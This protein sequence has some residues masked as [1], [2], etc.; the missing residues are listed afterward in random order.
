MKHKLICEGAHPAGLGGTRAVYKCTNGYG[1]SVIR[2]PFSY[3]NENGL[4]EVGVLKF[5]DEDDT[6]G[7]LVYTEL[8]GDT[9]VG[10]LNW[11]E[12][13][14]LLDA[15]SDIKAETWFELAK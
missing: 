11:L 10:H 4:Y 2:T 1:A 5:K 7:D 14:A 3:G 6:E 8:Y 12:V 9:V 15:I 13:L